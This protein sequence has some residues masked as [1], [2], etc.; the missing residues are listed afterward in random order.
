M[1][2]STFETL[3][4]KT[5]PAAD[6][7]QYQA[8]THPVVRHA[9]TRIGNHQPCTASCHLAALARRRAPAQTEAVRW[10]GPRTYL[11][12]N[13]RP[14]P[15]RCHAC[16]TPPRHWAG[17]GEPGACGPSRWPHTKHT[18]RAVDGHRRSYNDA[19]SWRA[20]HTPIPPLWVTDSGHW[21]RT[22]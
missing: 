19:L 22:H 3:P 12:T 2:I 9:A 8:P 15:R 16:R 4:T 6:E 20:L 5:P 11:G 1:A 17:V 13:P 7:T 10:V 14:I 18:S 21:V